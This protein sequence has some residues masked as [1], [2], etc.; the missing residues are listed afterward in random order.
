MFHGGSLTIVFIPWP[1]RG[2][3]ETYMTGMM[4]GPQ[5]E[6][7]GAG[8]GLKSRKSDSHLIKRVPKFRR[9]GL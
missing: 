9:N 8:C 1:L 5:P 6:N 2:A 4:D 3:N 7:D